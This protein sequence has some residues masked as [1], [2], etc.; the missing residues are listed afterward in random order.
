M[1]PFYLNSL[2]LN[3][4]PED[5]VM[6]KSKNLSKVMLFYVCGGFMSFFCSN[7]RSS[8]VIKCDLTRQTPCEMSKALAPCL[9]RPVPVGEPSRTQFR[10]LGL[11]LVLLK[12]A[13]SFLQKHGLQENWSLY[14][15]QLSFRGE[16]SDLFVTL[17]S[18]Q[19]VL[20]LRNVKSY[21]S[22]WCRCS[23]ASI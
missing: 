3:G 15:D 4:S 21:I 2:V 16:A 19:S 6:Q 14:Q 9:Q 8:V 13:T 10:K 22:E 20:T 12:I 7:G 23:V 5:R 18:V 11:M 17:F 1:G